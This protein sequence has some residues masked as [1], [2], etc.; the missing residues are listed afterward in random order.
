M[1]TNSFMSRIQGGQSVVRNALNALGGGGGKKQP[2]LSP[3]TTASIAQTSEAAASANEPSE[4]KVESS[5]TQ[6]FTS[7]TSGLKVS[8]TSSASSGDKPLNDGAVVSG[9]A[10]AKALEAQPSYL[11]YLSG[12][13]SSFWPSSAPTPPAFAPVK[14]PGEKPII[15]VAKALPSVKKI[16]RSEID[17]R[18]KGLF[19]KLLTAE[20]SSSRL[21]R[22]EELC[23]H[24]VQ[25]P[26]SRGIACNEKEVIKLLLRRLKESKD[27]DLKAQTRECLSL[28]GYV[29]PPKGQGIR[30]LSIDGG[31]TRGMM[32]LAVLEALEKECNGRKLSIVSCLVNTPQLQA[33][34]FRNYEHPIGRDSQY[35]G[36]CG[37]KMWQALQA[38][39]AAPGYFE[40]VCLGHLL[41]QDGGVLVNNPTA[42]GL[43]E[44]RLLW[45]H[46][47][48][49]CVVSVG[50]G[51][52]VT[53]PIEVPDKA[54]A[55]SGVQ[56][57]I[58]KIVDSAT[59]TELVHT[60]LRDLLPS[61][62]YYRLNPYMTHP[63]TLDEINP[64]KLDQMQADARLYVRKNHRKIQAAAR[65][66]LQPRTAFQKAM[67]RI[68][69][70]K[71]VRLGQWNA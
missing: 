24:L 32:G 35:R 36:G 21:L 31:G 20:S 2:A 26:E 34:I 60:S 14:K 44:A 43:H 56:A 49:Q 16:T 9:Q 33:Y 57:K 54:P 12:V 6:G 37:H 59:D 22:T 71:A 5:P 39:A 10:K 8:D 19:K 67:D 68:N 70:E 55:F 1:T 27:A 51:R 40:E 13:V 38:S 45:P 25:F 52:S 66:L 47:A 41:H 69:Y 7:P 42:I 46:S 11:G 17:N 62:D 48:I 30:I 64:G 63:Y 65:R 61:T 18:T 58:A 50:N 29:N 23:R 28:L 4:N 15:A 53:V 3:N